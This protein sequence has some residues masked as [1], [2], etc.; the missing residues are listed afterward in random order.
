MQLDLPLRAGRVIGPS[1]GVDAALDMGFSGDRVAALDRDIPAGQA[2]QVVDATDRIV[3]PGLI[4]LPTH[5]YRGHISLG[6]DTDRIAAR[7]GEITLINSGSARAGTFLGLL[8]DVQERSRARIPACLNVSCAERAPAHGTHTYGSPAF[9]ALTCLRP[10]RAALSSRRVVV[11]RVVGTLR[12]TARAC[13][14]PEFDCNRRET[15]GRRPE[16]DQGLRCE[17]TIRWRTV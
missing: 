14:I 5:V 6:V 13:E 16:V 17:R 3:T 1:S 2:A 15:L 9:R 7:S 8:R 12:G 4:D 10:L 11:I